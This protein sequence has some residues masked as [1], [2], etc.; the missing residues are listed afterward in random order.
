MQSEWHGGYW[1]RPTCSTATDSNPVQAST[2]APPGGDPVFNEHPAVVA[3]EHSGGAALDVGDQVRLQGLLRRPDLNGKEGTLVR[4]EPDGR[5]AVHLTG[6]PDVA[7][8][9]ENL[10]KLDKLISLHVVVLGSA[11]PLQDLRVADWEDFETQLDECGI[12]SHEQHPHNFKRD[13][14]IETLKGQTLELLDH[15]LWLLLEIIPEEVRPHKHLAELMEVKLRVGQVPQARL[16][17]PGAAAVLSEISDVKVTSAM[18]DAIM[19][20]R[21]VFPQCS[22]HQGR[23]GILDWA[24]GEGRSTLHRITA[25]WGNS[26]VSGSV[27][28]LLVAAAAELGKTHQQIQPIIAKLE[29]QWFDTAESLRTISEDDCKEMG[30]PKRLFHIIQ[31]ILGSS[32]AGGGTNRRLTGLTLRVGRPCFG[33]CDQ[34]Q[35]ILEQC[36]STLLIGQGGVGKST[37]LREI[38]RLLSDRFQKC[39]VVVDTTSELGGFGAVPHEALGTHDMTRLAVRVRSELF[40]VMLDAVQNHSARVVIVDELRDASEVA[41]ARTIANQGVVLFLADIS[42]ARKLLRKSVVFTRTPCCS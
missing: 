29:E 16:R 19:A 8:K 37:V 4:R 2:H 20:H 35:D 13:I 39:V 40:Q 10:D 27:G 36:T 6:S 34:I 22:F 32:E 38:A 14:S 30:I 1:R 25:V 24:S 9:P 18:L 7:V 3:V 17:Y 12:P 41:A 11:I 15:E 26:P 42:R 21:N 33:V 5:W 31:R 23:A 28:D